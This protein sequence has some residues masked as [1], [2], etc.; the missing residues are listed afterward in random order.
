MV[1]ATKTSSSGNMLRKCA[2]YTRKGEGAPRSGRGRQRKR[3]RE[4]KGGRGSDIARE[5]EN[6]R[7]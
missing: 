7:E 4:R 3:E 6:K 5:R 1:A 2:A